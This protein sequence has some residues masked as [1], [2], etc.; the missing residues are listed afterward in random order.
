MTGAAGYHVLH[1]NG[2][3]YTSRVDVTG[4]TSGATTL[5]VDDGAAITPDLAFF[6]VRAINGCYEESP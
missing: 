2:A 4:S 5:T 3:T 1:S 6:Q